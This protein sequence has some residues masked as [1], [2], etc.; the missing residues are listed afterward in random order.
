MKK[1]LS[2]LLCAVMIVAAFSGCGP[3]AGE[4]T[5]PSTDAA[6]VEHVLK[7]GYSRVDITPKE[8]VP[9]R[10]LGNSPERMSED[11]LDPLYATCVAFTDESDNTVL[12]YHLDLCHS[13]TAATLTLRSAVSRKTGIP[14]TQVMVTS[15]HNHSG[16]DLDLTD[17]PVIQAYTN[18]L[19]A[20][21]IQAAEE[22]L[23]DRKPAKMYITTGE[24]QNL[25]FI[26][27][28]KMKDGSVAGDNFGSF[29]SGIVEHVGKAD[30]TMQLVKFTR[31]GGKD[32][33]LMNWQGHPRGHGENRKAILSDVHAIRQEVEAALDC[34][35]AFY[36]GAS[37]NVN[38]SS[39]IPEEKVTGN[40][41]E[42]AKALTQ[43]AVKA[44]ESFE[45]VE[46]GKVQIIGQT[47]SGTSIESNQVKIDIPLFAFSIGDVAFI[48]APYEMFNE[49]GM[50]I[51]AG[52]PFKMTVVA[53]CANA[54]YTYIPTLPTFE[55][56]GYE[57]S[58]TKFVSG[59]A[60]K[61]VET[62]GTMLD[63]LKENS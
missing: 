41:H 26:R 38:N 23:A 55:Y 28:Y 58:M 61:L 50:A 8:S 53:T 1:L 6:P 60:E 25:N 46:V 10:G 52:S 24:A 18:S 15:T 56:G 49:S 11:V 27:H 51:K 31:E 63:Q 43:V 21:M 54:N 12:L 37:G 62:F 7:V 9:L 22:A 36:L 40:Y 32:V 16:P 57:V 14:G 48:T 20:W 44:A 17:N 59:T 30:N 33:L 35:F 2:L 39:R 29:A 45:E 19:K 13:F 5:Q 42:H 4:N 47:F 34:Q 3:Q